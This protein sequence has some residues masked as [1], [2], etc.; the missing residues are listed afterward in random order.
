MK[1]IM[2]FNVLCVAWLAFC[3]YLNLEPWTQVAILVP[4]MI[5]WTLVTLLVG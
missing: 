5:A 3:F 4:N 1:F 2:A